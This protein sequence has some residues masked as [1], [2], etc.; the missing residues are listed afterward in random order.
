MAVKTFGSEVLTSSDTNT[1][2]AN[3]GL[4]YI[5]QQSFSGSSAVSFNSVF[6]GTYDNYRIEA[7][8]YGSAFSF[9]LLRWRASGV[10]DTSASY[11]MR[12]WVNNGSLASYANTGV[13]N[14]FFMQYGNSVSLGAT[15]C[16][17]F[18]P[19]RAMRTGM[20]TANV[21]TYATD[22]YQAHHTHTQTLAYDGFTVYPNSGTLS[23]IIRVYGYRQA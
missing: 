22:A 11:A 9:A 21:D 6:N 20:I 17:V 5:T 13:T 8:C 23:G 1:Y 10:D 4:V 3:A 16:D 14:T 2:L 15:S 7:S 12:G 19:A 18:N